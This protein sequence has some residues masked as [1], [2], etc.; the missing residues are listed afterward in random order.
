MLETI[1][2]YIEQHHLLPEK[3]TVIVAVSGGA[4][5]LCLLHILHRLC[6]PS[7]RYPAVSLYVAHLDHQLRGEASAQDAAAV[8]ALARNW[9]L[10][11]SIGHADVLTLARQERRSIEEMA[12][13][14]RYNFLRNLAQQ[15]NAT[16]IA[17]A[18]HMDDQVETLL[19]HSLR[20]GG[21]A[22]MVGLQPHQ[23]DIIRPLLCVSRRDTHAYCA[24]HQIVPLD[25]AS[26]NDTRFL[27]NRIRHELL[28]L[29]T[30]MNPGYRH[31][32]LRNAEAMQLDLAWIET[33]VDLCW[34]QIVSHADEE[35][36]QLSLSPLQALPLS[37]QRHL[38]RRASALLCTGQSPLENR[39]H[40]LI[41]QLLQR[42]ST[43]IPL[44]LHLPQQLHLTRL[45]DRLVLERVHAASSP[46]FVEGEEHTEALLPIPGSV[47]VP[48]T[49]WLACT[50]LLSDE[51]LEQVYPAL[52][53]ADWATVWRLLPADQHQV[54]VDAE[55]LQDN[56]MPLQQ[57]QVRTRR[58]GD[59][60][61]PLGMTHA[62]KVQDI[63]VDKHVP[64]VQRTQIPL[65][66]SALH[67]IWLAGIQVDNRVR[68]TPDTRRIVRLAIAPDRSVQ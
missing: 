13:I 62:K 20:G 29:L 10:P 35:R 14:A 63:L 64:R 54:Y 67:C 7:K 30:E 61:Q 21:L 60:I 46:T 42:E 5:S 19:L 55:R 44:T 59:R 2:S 34:P 22:S 25:D 33:Q 9:H 53:S 23:Q 65:F 66:F 4:D 1:D 49:S 57:L 6:G 18:H 68:L 24:T 12:R 52:R 28:P 36:I 56:S 32:L 3:G 26:N 16:V 48:G 43:S 41:E 39:H 47:I 51:L 11:I 50:D 27:R 58:N 45:T 15:V 17:I 40:Q 37:L 31:T 8:A 38:L